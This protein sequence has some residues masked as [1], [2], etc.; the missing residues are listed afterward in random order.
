MIHSHGLPKRVSVMKG[1]FSG[2]ICL[3]GS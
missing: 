1:T 3:E 2:I